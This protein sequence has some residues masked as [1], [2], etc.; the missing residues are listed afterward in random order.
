MLLHAAYMHDIGMSISSS[1]RAE[2]MQDD[3]FIQLIEYLE[4]EGDFDMKKAARSVLQTQY[5]SRFESYLVLIKDHPVMMDKW[6]QHLSQKADIPSY[7][8]INGYQYIKFGA[9]Q[10]YEEHLKENE[11]TGKDYRKL[12]NL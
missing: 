8:L 6:I 1:E 3:S 11:I 7:Q 10:Y 9:Y 5:V 2:M 4:Q 12:Y